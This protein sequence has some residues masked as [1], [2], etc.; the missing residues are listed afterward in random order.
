M[1]AEK[2]KLVGEADK[3]WNKVVKSWTADTHK[4]GKEVKIMMFIFPCL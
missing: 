1:A 3:Q 4:K 2:R